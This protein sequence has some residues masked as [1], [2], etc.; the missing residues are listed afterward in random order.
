MGS[1][2]SPVERQLSKRF[3]AADASTIVQPVN[4]DQTVG[5]DPILSIFTEVKIDMSYI[6]FTLA[7]KWGA[8]RS[9]PLLLQSDYVAGAS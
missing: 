6:F 9:Y 3:W 2:A 5:V 1:R 4:H 8:C 7:I